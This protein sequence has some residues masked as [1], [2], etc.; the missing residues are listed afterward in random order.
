MENVCQIVMS[1]EDDNDQGQR[2]YRG[3]LLIL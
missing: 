2:Y 1:C 3:Y